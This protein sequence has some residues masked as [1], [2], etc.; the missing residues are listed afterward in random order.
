MK[1]KI[2]QKKYIILLIILIASIP[3]VNAQIGFP[4]D[5]DDETVAAPING[6]IWLALTFGGAL[7]IMKSRKK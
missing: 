5:V 3:A 1:K 6:L 2:N 4:D 7:G